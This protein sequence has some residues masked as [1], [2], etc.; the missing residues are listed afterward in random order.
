MGLIIDDLQAT[1][2]NLQTQ[3]DTLIQS[4]FI[5]DQA[6]TRRLKTI[7]AEHLNKITDL[8]AIL[9]QRD[10]DLALSTDKLGQQV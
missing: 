6:E 4:A 5:G 2:A 9:L 3:V 8:R 10:A 1:N 7:E